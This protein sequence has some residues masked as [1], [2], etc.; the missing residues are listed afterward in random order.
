LPRVV[1]EPGL[2]ANASPEA[3]GPSGSKVSPFLAQYQVSC[4]ASL[5]D[6]ASASG[7]TFSFCGDSAGALI[8]SGSHTTSL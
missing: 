2:Q 3:G 1:I 6:T 5:S 4:D 7:S 8:A